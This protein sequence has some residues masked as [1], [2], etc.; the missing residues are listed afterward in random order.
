MRNVLN[1]SVFALVVLAGAMLLYGGVYKPYRQNQILKVILP[2]TSDSAHVLRRELALL[3]SYDSRDPYLRGWSEL[4]RARTL[5][6]LGRN[7]E[8]RQA[9]LEGFSYNLPNQYLV[10]LGL[11][12]WELGMQEEAEAHLRLAVQIH[13]MLL[14]EIRGRQLRRQVMEMVEEGGREGK[15]KDER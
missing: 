7:D 9:Y 15:M 6:K 3:E 11:F 12:E 1:S 14:Q 10:E 4:A 8:A 2:S 13:P 5:R